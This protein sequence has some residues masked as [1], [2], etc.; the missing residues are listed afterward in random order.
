MEI[1]NS[2]GEAFKKYP[3]AGL[4]IAKI[5]DCMVCNER[6]DLRAGACFECCDRV[7]GEPVKG[8]HRLWEIK[9]PANTWYVGV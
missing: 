6:K 2:V 9:N 5:G 8:G 7:S 4:S 1:F 3:K